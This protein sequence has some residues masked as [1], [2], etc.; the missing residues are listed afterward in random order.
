M[1]MAAVAIDRIVVV[2]VHVAGGSND[3]MLT[4]KSKIRTRS[5]G[6][7]GWLERALSLLGAAICTMRM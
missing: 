2:V 7:S 5:G 3:A 6:D 1:E 4:G